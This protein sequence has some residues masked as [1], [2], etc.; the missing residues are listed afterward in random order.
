MN[1]NRFK[2]KH[3]GTPQNNVSIIYLISKAIINKS[4]HI[5]LIE[6]KHILAQ[7]VFVLNIA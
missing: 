3:Q 6:E 1:Y 5:R 4:M 2:A 7:I